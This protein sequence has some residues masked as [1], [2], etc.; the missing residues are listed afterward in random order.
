MDG[1]AVTPRPYGCGSEDALETYWY[2]FDCGSVSPGS[3]YKDESEIYTESVRSHKMGAVMQEDPNETWDKRV[4]LDFR[5]QT[6]TFHYFELLQCK[7][8]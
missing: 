1:R 2:R 5:F 8:L 3:S 6:F 7:R 4:C